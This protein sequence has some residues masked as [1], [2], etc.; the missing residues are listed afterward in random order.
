MYLSVRSIYTILFAL[1][2]FRITHCTTDQLVLL[3][4]RFRRLAD[5]RNLLPSPSFTMAR[6]FITTT[7][8][9]FIALFTSLTLGAN[10]RHRPTDHTKF[11]SKRDATLR[12]PYGSTKIRGVSIG[13]CI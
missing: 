3:L 10:H 6:A 12:F 7:I 9:C 4:R 8:F 1:P 2:A 5:Y 13:K 11:L